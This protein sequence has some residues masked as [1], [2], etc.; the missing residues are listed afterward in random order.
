MWE[1]R[2]ENMPCWYEL[3]WREEIPAI[4][5]K[6]H[7]DFTAAIEAI[8]SGKPD[9]PL[10][11]MIKKLQT[12]FKFENFVLDFN[13]NF[14]FDN[15]FC[16]IG[17]NDDLVEFLVGL[18][19][20]EKYTDEI[21]RYCEGTGEIKYLERKC[22]FCNGK[23]KNL[24]L[25]WKPADAISAS[26]TAFFWLAEFPRIKT[27]S[28]LPQ[29]LTVQ[30]ITMKQMGGGGL[31]GV[32]SPVLCQWLK[33]LGETQ[34]PEVIR[35]MKTAYRRMYS[36]NRFSEYYFR[37]ETDDGWLIIDCPGDR[38]S[39]YPSE[40]FSGNGGCEFSCHNVDNSIQQTTLI[41]GLAALHD[42]ARKEISNF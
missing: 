21:C 29:L 41:S 4:V 8:V 7:K 20:V 35:A 32:Y 40:R 31:G 9:L 38:C 17:E 23:G 22:S 26:L 16:R 19:V 37:A 30:T 15:A 1:L 2:T 36:L 12:E 11:Q 10:L 13:G 14:G 6:V 3:S 24:I 25:D 33:S 28:K 18:P 42:R 39:I 34:I 27:T 5:L